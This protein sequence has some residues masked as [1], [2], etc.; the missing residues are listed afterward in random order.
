[1]RLAAR[2]AALWIVSLACAATDLVVIANPHS[3]VERLSRAQTSAL[4]TGRHKRL[5]SGMAAIP[6]D[7]VA[8]KAAFYRALLGK[9]LPEVQSYWARIIFSGGGSPP[10]QAATADEVIEMV[11][12]NRGAIGYIPR[13]R[14][15]A[16]VRVVAEL[17]EVR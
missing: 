2:I 12:N 8:D 9:E 13:A 5:P 1:M 6:V 16:R 17:R 7:Q 3:G 14:A 4:F 15:D 10:Q 11:V